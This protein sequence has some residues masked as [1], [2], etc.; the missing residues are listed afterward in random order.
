[1]LGTLLQGI[2]WSQSATFYLAARA[3]GH[4]KFDRWI[5]VLLNVFLS[6]EAGESR[7]PDVIRS[8]LFVAHMRFGFWLYVIGPSPRHR[9]D[10]TRKDTGIPTS[11]CV[12]ELPS[13]AD[14]PG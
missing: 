3:G 4:S 9:R 11:M 5:V 1:M 12:A 6:V 8:T 7:R 13:R 2:C 10:L 14:P